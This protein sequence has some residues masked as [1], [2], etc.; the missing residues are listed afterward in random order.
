MRGAVVVVA[1]CACSSPASPPVERAAHVEVIADAAVVPDKP[2]TLLDELPPSGEAPLPAD[3][4]DEDIE[5]RYALA[6]QH[7]SSD[8]Q[9]ALA[10]LYDIAR[11]VGGYPALTDAWWDDAWA[12]QWDQRVFQLIVRH[13]PADS[14][15]EELAE[16]P[17]EPLDCP[18]GTTEKGEWNDEVSQGER[19]CERKNGVRH[20]P[21][22]L[23]FYG[24]GVVTK[25]GGYL[26]GKKHGF[27]DE[28]GPE[29]AYAMG[30]Y[31]HG[32]PHGLWFERPAE[33]QLV[34]AY[35][36]GKLHG[37]E[38]WKKVG[39][40][41]ASGEGSYDH[42]LPHGRFVT[43]DARGDVQWDLVLD[44]GTGHWIGYDVNEENIV[45]GE[46]ISGK[47]Q[48]TWIRT[49]PDGANSATGDYVDDQRDGAW[50]Y[51]WPDGSPRANGSFAMG[52]ATGRWTIYQEGNTQK[53]EIK[54][55]KLVKLDGRKPTA[56]EQQAF[57]RWDPDWPFR[58]EETE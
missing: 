37:V 52:K 27:W 55:G 57:G 29:D 9:R 51:V 31:D 32:V 2:R 42:G 20:G 53:L 58:I 11:A 45:E 23:A 34:H 3:A 35:V 14:E 28:S 19:W 15:Y 25:D 46:L 39:E 17:S 18:D 24:S 8:P 12:A 38:R 5:A 41:K 10:L 47:K 33:R 48:G 56:G 43:Y 13:Q 50:S 4:S 21:Y 44:H 22:E 30:A 7:A 1:L 26:E 49:G 36:D 16:H 6:V 54:G 40:V